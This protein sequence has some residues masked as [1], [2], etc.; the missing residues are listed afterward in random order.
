MTTGVICEPEVRPITSDGVFGQHSPLTN[1]NAKAKDLPTISLSKEEAMPGKKEITPVQGTVLS[2][3]R[4]DQRKVIATS[5]ATQV[6]SAGKIIRGEGLLDVV[7][8]FDTTG[9][10]DSKINALL[11]TCA[12]FVDEAKSLDL[13]SQFALISFGDISI[14]GGSDKIELVVPLTDNIERIKHGLAHIPRNSGYGNE[15]ETSLEAIQ[16]AFK[17]QYR[18]GTIKALILITDEPAVQANLKAKEM[19]EALAQKEFLVFVISPPEPYFKEMAKRNGGIWLEVAADTP[20]D[21]IL[22]MFKNIAKKVSE[23]AQEVTLI[24][25]GSVKEYLRLKAPKK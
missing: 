14:V 3:G 13:D 16:E 10:M 21:K 11:Q 19:I 20:L 17:I 2:V 4:G 22:E 7:F 6:K 24:T 25:D 5:Q 18:P 8:V 23:V 1:C 15:G 9:S 12:Q